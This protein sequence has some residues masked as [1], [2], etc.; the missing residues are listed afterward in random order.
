MRTGSVAPSLLAAALLAS[1]LTGCTGD[2]PSDQGETEIGAPQAPEP[3]PVDTVTT[4]RSVVGTLTDPR[5]VQVKTEIAAVV[6]HFVDNAYLGEFPRDSFAAAYRDFTPGAA[7][8]AKRDADLLSNRDLSSQIESAVALDRRLILEIF[9]PRRRP[10]GVTARFVLEYQTAGS[11][12]RIDRVK[13][14]LVLVREGD[15]WRVFGY[16]VIRRPFA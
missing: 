2:E 8:D 12:E 3:E 11:V 15:S 4:V 10:E 13:G 5:R 9:A 14:N 1:S 16:D 7:R 6:D